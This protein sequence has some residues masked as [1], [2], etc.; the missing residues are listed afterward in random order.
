MELCEWNPS[1]GSIFLE[2]AAGTVPLSLERVPLA[3]PGSCQ[4][5]WSAGV[6]LLRAEPRP[7]PSPSHPWR[8]LGFR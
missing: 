7:A 3:V 1:P 6:L 8:A 4:T 5:Q 2:N